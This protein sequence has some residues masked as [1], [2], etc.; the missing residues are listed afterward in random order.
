MRQLLTLLLLLAAPV[1]AAVPSGFAETVYTSNDLIQATG[2]AWAP[3]GSGRLFVT[4]KS[5]DVRVVSMSNGLPRTTTPGGTT[6]VTSLFAREL[7]VETNSECG[8][9][10]IAVDPN[11][12]VNRYVYIFVTVSETEQQIVRYTD[13]DGVGTA[14]TVIVSGLPTKGQNH[15][16]GALGFGPDGKLY[17][18]IGDLGNGTGVDADL[19]SLAAKV[20]RVNRD[21]SPVNDNPFN[22]GVGPN[23]ERIWARGFR[24]PFTLTF[25]PSTGLLWLNVV[26]TNYEQTFVVKSAAHGGYN[27]YENNQPATNNYI[28]PVI[29]YRTGGIDE[30]TLT[31]SGAVRSGGVT[32]FTTTGTHGFRKGEKLTLAGVTDTSFNGDFYVASTPSGTTFTV[33]QVGLADA[34]SGGGSAKTQR[35]GGC[36]NGGVFYDATLF[37][38]EYRGNYFFG[39]YV[40][41]T[42]M[43]AT[44]AADNTMA[45]VD[46]WGTSFTSYIDAAVG[47]DGALYTIGFQGRLRRIVPANPGQRLVVSGLYPR[48]VE[49]GQATFTVRLAQAPT[50][51][52]VVDV[53]RAPGG[54]SDLRISGR[55]T[56]TF[57]PDDWSVPR[58]VTLEALEDA[59][60]VQDTA[61]FTV[62]SSGLTSESV[63]ATTIEDNSA[64]LVLS[65]SNVNVPE[66]GTATFT[67][68]LSRA[69]AS[70]VTVNVA[71]A[72][73][74]AD[75]TVQAGATLTLTPT[76]WNTPQTV[77]LA[78]AADADNADGVAT[79]AVSATGLDSRTVTATEVDKDDLA[80]DITSTA[81]TRAV[82]GN[83]YRYDVDARARP[84]AQY[85]LTT[86]P[87]GMSIDAATGLITWTPTTA[88]TV[89]VAV[90]VTNGVAPDATQTFSVTVTQDEPPVAKLTH[91]TQE[92][93]VSG[94]SAEFYGDC[95]DDVGCT[96]AEF[97]VDGERRYVDERTDNH[98]HFGGEHNRWDTTDLAPGGHLVRFVVVDTRGNRA[99]AEVKVCV[100]TGDCTLV[101][102]DAGTPDAGTPDAGGGVPD[103]GEEPPLPLPSGGGCG[104][105]AAPMGALAWGALA[106]LALVRRR[107]QLR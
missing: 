47:P 18:A 14:R 24:N 42:F 50:S 81:L 72:S 71:R 4:I 51:P 66:G 38:P 19:T 76:D 79:I 44:L 1:W 85:S 63:L 99:E 41:A 3:D 64:Q 87:P 12:T 90:R 45:T 10:G 67:V 96:H 8:V 52:M 68:A 97:Y 26:G 82:V 100:G 16:G 5:G 91:P 33:A 105:G 21:G 28:T 78:A 65:S 2:M 43:R 59:D 77:T 48:V 88:V 103:A 35:L 23:N 107:R 73:G 22:D 94:A 58:V 95:E 61:T 83:P 57:T 17:F 80:P 29:K 31:A 93:R 55:A 46:S 37:P 25:Q 89:D 69:P 11:Y 49:G 27:D 104:C 70:N 9:I 92:E 6:L 98:F 39:D 74:D 86:S 54:S 40:D 36:M 60:A 101:P 106:V 62:S 56:F 13:L 20:S 75:L 53:Y 30:R 32:T 84:A 34:S 7:V 15:D 102:P